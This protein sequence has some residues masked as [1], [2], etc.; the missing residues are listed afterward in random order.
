MLQAT[1]KLE[2]IQATK[3]K[4]AIKAQMKVL[5]GVFTRDMWIYLSMLPTFALGRWQNYICMTIF[6][7]QKPVVGK[8]VI[9]VVRFIYTEWNRFQVLLIVLGLV[10]VSALVSTLAWKLFFLAGVVM[11]I[12]CFGITLYAGLKFYLVMP[13]AICDIELPI[14]SSWKL[15]EEKW[16]ALFG[17]TFLYG[18]IVAV[19][20]C[21]LALG[22]HAIVNELAASYPGD[23][24]SPPDISTLNGMP[25]IGRFISLAPNHPFSLP[26][27]K[28]LGVF[29]AINGS[30]ALVFMGY[31]RSMAFR[32][33]SRQRG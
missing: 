33:F 13:M 29:S 12:I 1:Y 10:I 9:S 24:F 8:P 5:S 15:T 25:E 2:A 30:L 20:Y 19:F 32:F 22:E 27:G 3:D 17:N 26:V 7:H 14:K 21:G 23:F 31:Y 28:S 18:F 4:E 6:L 16:W 11:T